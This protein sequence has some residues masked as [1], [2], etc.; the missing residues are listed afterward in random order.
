MDKDVE[1]ING[2]PIKNGSYLLEPRDLFDKAIIETTI[3]GN[4]VYCVDKIL[5]LLI[6]KEDPF[7]EEEAQEHFYFNILRSSEYL[8]EDR[9]PYFRSLNDE[10]VF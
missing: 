3:N 1:I 8:P 7:T 10:D 5:A 9:R 4:P 6:E 2:L